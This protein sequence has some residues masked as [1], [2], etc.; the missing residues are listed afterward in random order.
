M[1]YGKEPGFYLLVAKIQSRMG[2]AWFGLGRLEVH[3]KIKIIGG[4][5]FTT[6]STR[7]EILKAKAQQ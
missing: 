2:P 7:D 5:T 1:T 6:K 4:P 3:F